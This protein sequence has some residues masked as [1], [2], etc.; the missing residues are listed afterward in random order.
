MAA[1]AGEDHGAR[2]M[3]GSPEGGERAE[4]S[5]LDHGD[6]GA[7][8]SVCHPQG[9]LVGQ[10]LLSQ[11]GAAWYVE[12]VRADV[13]FQRK[14]ICACKKK[15]CMMLSVY[16]GVLI[17]CSIVATLLCPC[18]HTQYASSHKLYVFAPQGLPPSTQMLHCAKPHR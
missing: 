4:D 9:F 7:P 5:G 3:V 14:C 17:I 6:E 16:H 1:A 18:P 8:E 12:M 15:P 11:V 10:R 2:G 13:N